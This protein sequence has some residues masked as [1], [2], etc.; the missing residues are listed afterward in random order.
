MTMPVANT[1]GFRKWNEIFDSIMERRDYTQVLQEFNKRVEAIGVSGCDSAGRPLEERFF[2]CADILLDIINPK[3]TLAVQ[4]D[5]YEETMKAQEIMA[6][7][8]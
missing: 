6:G 7:L 8:R 4:A 3:V 5:E 2:L 1:E